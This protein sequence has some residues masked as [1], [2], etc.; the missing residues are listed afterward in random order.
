MF[1]ALR[2]WFMVYGV[3]FMVYGLWFM[4]YGLW[5]MVYGSRFTVHGLEFEVNGLWFR[6]QGLGFGVCTI[7]RRMTMLANCGTDDT[8]VSNITWFCVR[9][10]GLRARDLL[11]LHARSVDDLSFVVYVVW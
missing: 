6:V 10:S 7:S 11:A 5:F 9:C 1:Y 3:W 4:V 8:V 2:L